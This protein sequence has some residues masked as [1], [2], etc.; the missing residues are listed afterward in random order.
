[1]NFILT[2]VAPED[3]KLPNDAI[4]AAC[5]LFGK[6]SAPNWLSKGRACDLLFTQC[7]L[8]T[9]PNTR[10]K[11]ATHLTEFNIDWALQADKNRRKSVLVSDMDSTIIGQECIDEIADFAGVRDQVSNITERAMAGALDFDIALIER[12]R[13]LKGLSENAIN[14]VMSERI[15]LNLGAK[16]LLATMRHHG[17]YTMLV[18]GGFTFCASRIAQRAGF[19]DFNANQLIFSGTN[20][21]GKVQKPILGREAK[22]G[23]LCAACNRRGVALDQ[24][25]GIGDGANDIALVKNAGIGIAYKAK[26]KLTEN[27]DAC[28][29]HT[30]LTTALFFQGYN[31]NEFIHE[32]KV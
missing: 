15:H 2:L 9:L 8:S 17:A 27:A 24:S 25:I 12:V 3:H 22:L 4:T 1:M 23:F 18:S 20:L 5:N 21:T 13:L 16:T 30:D 10:D 32:T 29:T 11:L 19:D 26:Q 28:I 31:E 14:Q 6:S 7:D